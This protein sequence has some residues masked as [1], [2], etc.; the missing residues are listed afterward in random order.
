MIVC[1]R[2]RGIVHVFVRA[3]SFNCHLLLYVQYLELSQLSSALIATT[4]PRC[5]LDEFR[6]VSIELT[7]S[8]ICMIS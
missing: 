6:A 4:A 1:V 8:F 5:T 3:Y 7:T 2:S